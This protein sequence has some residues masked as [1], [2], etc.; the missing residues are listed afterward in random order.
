MKFIKSIVTATM[1]LFSGVS[2]A[3]FGDLLKGLEKLAKDLEEGTQQQKAQPSNPQQQSQPQQ[4]NLSNDSQVNSQRDALWE[5][6]KKQETKL[7]KEADE[8]GPQVAKAS[9][10]KFKLLS[11]KDQ[12]TGKETLVARY[13]A[14]IGG[15]KATTD[16]FCRNDFLTTKTTFTNIN[17]PTTTEGGRLIANGRMRL[18]GSVFPNTYLNDGNFSNVFVKDISEVFGGRVG[19]Q[20]RFGFTTKGTWEEVK[21]QTAQYFEDCKNADNS[22]IQ[23]CGTFKP[24]FAQSVIV[25]DLAMEFNTASGKLFIEMSPYDPAI[26]RVAETCKK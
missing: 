20:N 19:G 8:K 7:V 22:W 21:G 3:Q 5:E 25:Y 12:M 10:T 6:L 4:Q 26:K 16:I 11:S 24:R 1:I 9:K 2:Y 18:N 14:S 15:G 13:E 17:L 23:R